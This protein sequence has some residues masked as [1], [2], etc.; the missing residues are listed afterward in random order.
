MADPRKLLS[1]TPSSSLLN[2]NNTLLTSKPS[3]STLNS[4]SSSLLQ[5]STLL[6]SSSLSTKSSFLP[7][8]SSTQP[9]SLLSS[10]PSS[11]SLLNKSSVSASPSISLINTAARSSTAFTSIE[12]KRP[13]PSLIQS[14]TIFNSSTLVT[15]SSL[16]RKRKAENLESTTSSLIKTQEKLE[17]TSSTTDSKVTS[18][19]KYNNENILPLNVSS[20]RLIDELH[21]NVPA[22]KRPRIDPFHSIFSSLE[23]QNINDEDASVGIKSIKVGETQLLFINQILIFIFFFF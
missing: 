6:S 23:N 13:T 19:V 1:K 9:L 4:S 7:N 2:T 22:P 16:T 3:T 15:E 11:S 20:N 18:Q 10:I 12:P 17:Q 14:S 5:G 8:V 21:C